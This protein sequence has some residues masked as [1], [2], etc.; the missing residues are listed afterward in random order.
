MKRTKVVANSVQNIVRVHLLT[1]RTNIG[2]F[3]TRLSL[4]ICWD[5]VW[6]T[7]RCKA[8]FK[9]ET[10]I[11]LHVAAV[12][13]KSLPVNSA[14]ALH[15]SLLWRHRLGIPLEISAEGGCW[16]CG[17]HG[18]GNKLCRSADPSG[19]IMG[20][21][22]RDERSK[23]KIKEFL[24]SVVQNKH[25]YCNLKVQTCTS[26]FIYYKLFNLLQA[27]QHVHVVRKHI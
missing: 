3:C 7:L 15:H 25:Y 21:S 1:M 12:L 19:I 6:T 14:P 16:I 27:F 9:S 11:S 4:C 17:C 20:T 23:G 8:N 24:D 2:V 26:T 10:C 5:P 13:Q 18:C 22:G